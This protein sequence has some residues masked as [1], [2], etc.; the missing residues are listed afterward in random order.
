M[1]DLTDTD[2]SAIAAEFLR[3]RRRAGSP[4]M[5]MVMTLVVVVEE[6][7]ANAAMEVA[8]TAAREHPARLLG[9]VIGNGRSTVTTLTM[10]AL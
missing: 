2:S 8:R 5:G 6:D 4:A 10:S 3:A 7:G 9:V 1:I